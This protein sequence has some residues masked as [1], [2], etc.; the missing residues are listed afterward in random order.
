MP[1]LSV[2]IP[3][4]LKPYAFHGVD[5]HWKESDKEAVG[6]CPW[7][8]REN[9]FFVSL[10]TGQW[11]CVVCQEGT[12]KGGGNSYV[13]LRLL[14]QESMQAAKNQ[15]RLYQELAAD[16]GLMR[17]ATLKRWGLAPSILTGDW[18]VPG[19]SVDGKINQVYRYLKRGDR[20]AQVPTSGHGHQLFGLSHYDAKKTVN[21]LAE[22]VWD[23]MCLEE[24]L[25]CAK[26]EKDGSLSPTSSIKQSLLA[27]A[28]V[29]AVPACSVFFNA[30]SV[31]FASKT[32]NLMYDND[33]PR[34][35][36]R[37]NK[38]ISSAGFE[39]MK[40]VALILSQSSAPPSQINYLR[41]GETGYDLSLPSGYDVR[42]KLAGATCRIP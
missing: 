16:R 14:W 33:H 5:L 30:W 39:G 8:G 15:E 22:G 7:C 26:L 9:K 4:K 20:K 35:H 40:R 12:A 34:K 10:E 24:H 23:A 41:W 36:P 13:F 38:E 42:D 27:N 19:Y 37:T 3:E 28:C 31:L 29:L 18:L 6:E 21:Y 11:R 2:E 25:T 1:K 17:T 32:V